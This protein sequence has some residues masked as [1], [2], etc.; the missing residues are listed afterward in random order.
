M[1]KGNDMK[2]GELQNKLNVS[3]TT[4]YR[5]MKGINR[6]T[7]DMAQSFISALD[8]DK[9]Q[10]SEFSKYVSLSAFDHTLIES[11]HVLDDFLF[12]KQKKSKPLLDVEMVLYDKDKYLRTLKEILEHIFSFSGKEGLV[13]E[14]KI[15]NCL[16]E[17]VFVLLADYLKKVFTAGININVEHFIGLSESNYL[18]N[19]CAFTS[20]FPLIMHEKYEL[21]CRD[22]ETEDNLMQDS[23]LVS[24]TYEQDGKQ[25]S[26]FF[27]ITFY[28]KGMSECVAFS[29][30]YMYSYFSKLF[31]NLKLKYR[32]VMQKTNRID[33]NEDL[34]IEMQKYGAGYV[35]KPN[36]CYDKIPYEAYSSLINRMSAEE[37]KALLYSLLGEKLDEAA[38]PDA[39]SKVMKYL[40]KRID[41]AQETKQIDVY[42]KEGLADFAQSGKLTDH[43]ENLPAFNQDER[44][45]VL[46]YLYNRSNDPDDDYLLYITDS[47]MTHKD[48]VLVAAKYFGLLIGY[49]YPE[50]RN[51]LWRM[52]FIQNERLASIFC[53][54]IENHIPINLAIEKENA[55]SFLKTLIE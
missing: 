42:S 23:I 4:L 6:I 35:I 45:M 8:M 40:K 44:R 14:I 19:T 29:D 12:G 28:E 51:G 47:D 38:I 15:V 49:V 31:E 48:L 36:P 22:K 18:Q 7:P 16:N 39:I 34:F 46:E 11:R 3:R 9:D 2:I 5:Y 10:T 53:D 27:S 20:V 52:I 25:S 33:F 13:G 26:R 30:V 50:H 1:C 17:N 55:S 37:L 21:Y 32:N 54:Y 41:F 24:L 43:L